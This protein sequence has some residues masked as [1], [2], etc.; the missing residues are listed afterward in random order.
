MSQ[1]HPVA[2]SASRTPGGTRR[3][4]WVGDSIGSGSYGEKYYNAFRLDGDE[5]HV[6]DCVFVRMDDEEDDLWVAEVESLWEDK[7][8]EKWFEGRWFYS[9]TNAR[10][11]SGY[12]QGRTF[13]GR[14]WF[15]ANSQHELFESDHVDENTIDCVEGKPRL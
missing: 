13:N 6:G 2:R 11:H 3:I 4:R 12:G 5:Y 14:N 7:Y 15:N 10:A 1:P 9:A 8:T